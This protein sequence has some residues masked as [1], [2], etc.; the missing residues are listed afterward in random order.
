[1]KLLS[2]NLDSDL[3]IKWLKCASVNFSDFDGSIVVMWK[4]VHFC[5]NTH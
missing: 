4:N 2:E 1:M 3:R 5:R